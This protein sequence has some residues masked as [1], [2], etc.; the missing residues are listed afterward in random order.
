MESKDSARQQIRAKRASNFFWAEKSDRKYYSLQFIRYTG[1][2][3][4][5][6]SILTPHIFKNLL[7]SDW[8]TVM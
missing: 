1:D 7:V 2:L 3:K 5:L 4:D 6:C 8:L